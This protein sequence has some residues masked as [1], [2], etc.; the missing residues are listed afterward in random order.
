M[1]TQEEKLEALQKWATQ[2]AIIKVE[3]LM[4]QLEEDSAILL[5][6]YSMYTSGKG[7]SLVTRY[8][9]VVRDLNGAR[10]VA[11]ECTNPK[12]KELILKQVK[13]IENEQSSN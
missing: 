2:G 4:T 13:E 8:T 3:P 11:N 1:I 6:P 10:R 9:L 5:S 12:L 7:M